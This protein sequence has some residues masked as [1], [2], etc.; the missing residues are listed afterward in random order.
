MSSPIKTLIRLS[1]VLGLAALLSAC[2]AHYP[3]YHSERAAAFGHGYGYDHGYK[4]GRRH[5]HE[6]RWRQ[7]RHH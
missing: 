5:G 6:K 2:Y 3:R 4:D 1:A 7:R